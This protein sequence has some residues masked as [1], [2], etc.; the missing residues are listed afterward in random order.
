[1]DNPT[2]IYTLVGLGLVLLVIISLIVAFI[3]YRRFN[4]GHS[5]EVATVQLAS[6]SHIHD[7]EFYV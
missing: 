5:Y 6:N 3:C 4:R 2:L 1:M 7:K